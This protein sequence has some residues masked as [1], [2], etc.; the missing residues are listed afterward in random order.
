MRY[1][2]NTKRKNS[3]R[4]T[5]RGEKRSNLTDRVPKI[6]FNV[7]QS[8]FIFSLLSSF[9]YYSFKQLK[10]SVM[11]LNRLRNEFASLQAE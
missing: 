4:I 1:L 11:H 2:Q 7:C 9:I 6:L 5:W 3:H 10:K 8:F